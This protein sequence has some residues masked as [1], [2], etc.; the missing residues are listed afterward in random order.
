M[1]GKRLAVDVGGTFIDFMLFD[2]E[3]RTL[4]IEK[5]AS[6]GALEKRFLEGVDRLGID[7]TELSMIVHGS[8]LV[9]NTI[10]QEKGAR[11]G[12]ITTRGF[13]DVYELGRG[14]RAEI[15]NLFYRPPEPLI[16]RFL[17]FEVSERLSANGTVLEALDEATVRE[18]VQRLRAEGVDGIAVALLHAY[19]NPRHEG[20]IAEI[21]AEEFP[22]A[23]VSLSSAVAAEWREFERTSTTVLNAYVQP[24]VEAYLS[25]LEREL[26]G[27]GY[28]APLTIMQS[29][30]GMTSSAIARSIPIRTL[31]SGPAGGVIGSAALGRKLNLPNLVAAD[32][33]GTT[34]DVALIVDGEPLEKAETQV[35]RRP[36]LQPTLDI[37]S[38]GAGG[39]SIAWLDGEGGLR[40]GPRS[41][42]A[43]PGPA[44]FGL[45]GT[46]PTVTDAQIVLGYLDPNYYLGQRMKLDRA[47]AE[48]AIREKIAVPLQID[49]MQAAYGIY[50]LAVMNMTYAIRNLTI[51]RGH[52]PRPFSLA[53][54]GGGGGLFASHLLNELECAQAIVPVNPANFSSWGL[55]NA[56]YREDLTRMFVR[57]LIEIQPGE[58]QGVLD[59]MEAEARQ[60][61]EDSD[62]DSSGLSTHY[63]AEMRYLGQEHTVRVPL[64][65]DDLQDG[66]FAAL[67][68]RFNSLHEKAYA[69]KLPE[70]PVEIVRLRLAAVVTEAKP[71]MFPIANTAQDALKGQRP[72]SFSGIGT[73]VNCPVY[74]R[75][76]LVSGQRLEGPLIVEEWT[77]T[78][79]V[80]PGQCLEVDGYGNLMISR[81]A[82]A[83]VNHVD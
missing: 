1:T 18:A 14:N 45:G 33:G 52:D 54:F 7:L 80:L 22:E 32:V 20:R 67:R 83:E 63:F 36:V 61:L 27:R 53:C 47:A 37:V 82:S 29:S 13:R 26:R 76:R 39:G 34:F 5:V 66:T 9:I 30:G 10:V 71:E 75:P 77:S 16:P 38:I 43:N 24:R 69:H 81:L 59:A 78:T 65:A 15:Y 35:N 68:Q 74:D 70:K 79:L 2:A 6:S 48:N 23:H 55:L 8:T 46:E 56:D 51:E 21:I 28:H 58:L 73:P 12:L 31:E 60:T 64:L 11:L 17:R 62:I 40:V 4:Q 41:A 50:H 25:G 19:A 72:V 57:P 44:C 49:L 3:Q 42:E